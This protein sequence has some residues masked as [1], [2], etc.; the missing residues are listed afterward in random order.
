M[1]LGLSSSDRKEVIFG[2]VND[3]LAKQA[4]RY[5][6]S[7]TQRPWGGF[8]V[9]DEAQTGDFVNLYFPEYPKQQISQYGNKL[10]PKILVVEPGK[11][12]SWQYH[13]RRAELWRTLEGPVGVITSNDNT[14]GPLKEL[15]H[16]DTIQFDSNIRHRLIG[17]ENWGVVAEIWQHTDAKNPSN[18]EDIVR[19]EDDF[20]RA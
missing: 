12:L 4:L 6:S 2:K 19:V 1:E 20:N 16:G 15:S 10:S 5:V 3:Y 8:F 7:D 17:L 9:I 11:R 14:Q 13:N 18:E